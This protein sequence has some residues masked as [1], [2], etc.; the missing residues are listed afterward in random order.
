MDEIISEQDSF[1]NADTFDDFM[2]DFGVPKQSDEFKPL[3]RNKDNTERAPDR[4]VR[5]DR[6]PPRRPLARDNGAVAQPAAPAETDVP[7]EESRADRIR[8]ERQER[9]KNLRK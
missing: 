7:K 2:S 5:P 9:I 1:K 3:T 4:R 6:E 8:R